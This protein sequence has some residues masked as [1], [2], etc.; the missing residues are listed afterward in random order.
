MAGVPAP[1]KSK[2][3]RGWDSRTISVLIGRELAQLPN[4]NRHG[5]GRA[6]RERTVS[7][8]PKSVGRGSSLPVQRGKGLKGEVMEVLKEQRGRRDECVTIM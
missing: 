8:W 1:E 7:L 2:E 4:L 6:G 3:L 5:R